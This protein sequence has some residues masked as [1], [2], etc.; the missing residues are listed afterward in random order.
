MSW[1]SSRVLREAYLSQCVGYLSHPGEPD[2]LKGNTPMTVR[3]FAERAEISLSLAY[4]LIEEG[5]VPHRRI[6]R[7]GRRGKIVIREDDLIK[8]LESVRVA[9]ERN[10]A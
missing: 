3:E 8:F 9:A 1:T 5:R 7:A 6:G 10:R 4:A 2:L